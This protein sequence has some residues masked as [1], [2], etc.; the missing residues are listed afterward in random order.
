[1]ASPR[2]VCHDTGK[3]AVADAKAGRSGG[4]LIWWWRDVARRIRR[5]RRCIGTGLG[6]GIRGSADNG[7]DR[8]SRCHTTPVRSGIIVAIAAAAAVDVYVPI[9]AYVGISVDVCI[10]VDVRIAAVRH[11]SM[12]VVGV[13]VAASVSPGGALPATARSPSTSAILYQ[14]QPGLIGSVNGIDR[15]RDTVRRELRS[16]CRH[17]AAG[18]RQNRC[19][20][21]CWCRV[22]FNVPNTWLEAP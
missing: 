9:S 21:Q 4:R 6:R 14:D 20:K 16:W 5:W 2:A 15:S 10:S 17:G 3:V 11:V 8:D 18:K 12:E 7:T 19:Q 1:M 13:E 22:H